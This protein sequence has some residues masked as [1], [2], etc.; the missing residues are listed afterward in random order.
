MPVPHIS[1]FIR[2]P[3][4]DR[5][6]AFDQRCRCT[7]DHDYFIRLSTAG[8]GGVAIKGVVGNVRTGGAADG[9]AALCESWAIAA[10]HGA[11]LSRRLY[12]FGRSF[13]IY[14]VRK[15]A[16]RTLGEVRAAQL[17]AQLGSRHAGA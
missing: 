11:P 13:A 8:H 10:R 3:A 4:L 17:L 1:I 9:L 15:I 6:G 16:R 14:P 7:S 5:V 12:R 2:R